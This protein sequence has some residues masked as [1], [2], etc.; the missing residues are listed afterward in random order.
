MSNINNTSNISNPPKGD[1]NRLKVV[2]VEQKNSNFAARLSF[3]FILTSNQTTMKKTKSNAV[4]P[5][6][7][8]G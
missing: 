6:Q 5:C 1:I 4:P 8:K 3:K 7:C 2:L